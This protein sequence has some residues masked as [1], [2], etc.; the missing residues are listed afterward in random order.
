M[1]RIPGSL[2]A[3]DR[4]GVQHRAH[5]PREI[6]CRRSCKL[7]ADLCRY[8]TAGFLEKDDTIPLLLAL[9]EGGADVSWP[10]ALRFRSLSDSC[11]RVSVMGSRPQQQSVRPCARS[12][13]AL[14]GSPGACVRPDGCCGE[15]AGD[16]SGRALHRPHGRRHHHPAR[17]RGW[18][19]P[20]PYTLHLTPYTLTLHPALYTLYTLIPAPCTLNHRAA[21][22]RGRPE[23]A[24]PSSKPPRIRISFL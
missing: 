10:R 12:L 19:H 18:S 22:Q 20:T 16:R 1:R 9:Q 5:G 7:R 17:Q 3:G 23:S 24:S 14:T 21:G 11:V 4:R 13:G 15:G 2:C 6:F 8:L